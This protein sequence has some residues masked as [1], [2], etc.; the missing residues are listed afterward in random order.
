[1][2]EFGLVVACSASGTKLP[3]LWVLYFHS[4]DTA[5]QNIFNRTCECINNRILIDWPRPT[6]IVNLKSTGIY[7][8]NANSICS[9][10][11][12]VIFYLKS[13]CQVYND[14]CAVNICMQVKIM[15]GMEVVVFCFLSCYIQNMTIFFHSIYFHLILLK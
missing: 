6:A 4:F 11:W 13:H 9:E 12:W 1:M 14:S 2:C 8:L 5:R 7:F 10:G 15:N 3:K